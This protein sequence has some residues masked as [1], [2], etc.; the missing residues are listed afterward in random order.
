MLAF[1]FQ[2]VIYDI[3]D[4]IMIMDSL[5]DLQIYLFSHRIL[6]IKSCSFIFIPFCKKKYPS[7][8]VDHFSNAGF[9]SEYVTYI[10]E[11]TENVIENCVIQKC[12]FSLT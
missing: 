8:K 5:R 2:S 9:S 6:R 12:F 3:L 1:T 11:Y 7:I 4:M 10:L